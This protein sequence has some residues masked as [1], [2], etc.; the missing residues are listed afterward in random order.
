MVSTDAF[1]GV[2]AVIANA[3][4]TATILAATFGGVD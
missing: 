3:F 1:G 2:G 4:V